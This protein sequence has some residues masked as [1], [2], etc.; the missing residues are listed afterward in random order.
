MS[1][2]FETMHSMHSINGAI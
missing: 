1:E 2:R